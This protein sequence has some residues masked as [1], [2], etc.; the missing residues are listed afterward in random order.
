VA[1]DNSRRAEAARA[2]RARIIDAARISFV[3]QGFADTTVRALAATAEVS[4]ETIYKSFGTKAGLLKAVYDVSLVGDDADVPFA[5]RPEALAA[6]A[7]T[8]GEE[9]VVRYAELAQLIA[10]RTDPLVR[11][12]MGSRDTDAALSAFV[13]TIHQERWVGSAH[14]VRFLSESGWLREDLDLDEATDTVWALNSYEPRW[15]LSDRGWSRGQLTAW[16]AATLARALL[17]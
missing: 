14:W 12:M 6:R 11:V 9:A 8:S 5:H 17:P 13:D 7:A 4:P 1:Y 3:E 10:S 16:L 2:T 15:L